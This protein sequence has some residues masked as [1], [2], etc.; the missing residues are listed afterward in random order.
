[1]KHSNEDNVGVKKQ[2]CETEGDYDL[3]PIRLERLEYLDR[4][5]KK[6]L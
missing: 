4:N 6:T 1:M 5:A 2:V 3:G